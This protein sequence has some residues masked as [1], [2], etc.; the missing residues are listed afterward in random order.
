MSAIRDSLPSTPST[1]MSVIQE[2]LKAQEATSMEMA[3]HLESL[4]THYDQMASA[5]RDSEAGE[6]F[7]EDDLQGRQ[8]CVCALHNRC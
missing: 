5:L 4:A 7:S 3:G 2:V 1:S 6:D 8:T